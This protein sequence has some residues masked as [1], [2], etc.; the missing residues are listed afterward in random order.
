MAGE[1][2]ITKCA[3]PVCGTPFRY[4][5]GGRLFLMDGSRRVTNVL[6]EEPVQRRARNPEYFW[7]CKQCC[8]TMV[9]DL[10]NNGRAR[11]IL[12]SPT[13]CWSGPQQ[14]VGLGSEVASD[15][16]QAI[17]ERSRARMSR[18]VN[19]RVGDTVYHSRLALGKGKVRYLYRDEVLVD[20]EKAA[21]RR[22]SRGEI[23]KSPLHL[24]GEPCRSCGYVS[25]SAA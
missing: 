12:A 9:I 7:L 1:N 14:N 3:N 23:C 15:D 25:Q 4:F 5:R 18:K 22:Y 6:G 11:V 10:D 13:F 16:P 21:V 8:S 19:L 17:A 24:A 20:F 2:V